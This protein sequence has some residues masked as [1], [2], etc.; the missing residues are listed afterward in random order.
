MLPGFLINAVLFCI[1]FINVIEMVVYWV[2]L[3]GFCF[4]VITKL[5]YLLN[6]GETF[7]KVIQIIF[8]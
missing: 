6:Q 2:L 7:T 1:V 5:L 8:V 3:F 4:Q